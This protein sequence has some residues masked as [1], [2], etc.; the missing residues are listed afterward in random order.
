MR[1]MRWTRSMPSMW[2]TLGTPARSKPSRIPPTHC[3]GPHAKRSTARTIR[4][5]PISGD[6][7]HRYPNASHA[8]DALYWAAFALYKNDNLDRAR[9]LLATQQQRYP[10]AATLRDGDALLA[11]VQAALAK[12]GDGEAAEWIRRH[13]QPA[14]DTGGTRG[15]NC[16]GEDDDD[17]LRVAALNGLLQMD[18]TSALPILKKVLAK[19]DACSAGLRRKAVFIVSQKRGDETEDILLDVAR[20]DPK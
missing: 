3:G 14:A 1:S 16:P 5:P 17:D 4:L 10:K 6:L 18:A 15:G 11:R 19:R 12:Q 7:A 2:S 8:G 13:A 20:N 9:G